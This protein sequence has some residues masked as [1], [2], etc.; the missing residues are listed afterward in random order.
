[1]PK[2]RTSQT[3]E[4]RRRERDKQLKRQAKL[5][6]R[7]ERNA[8]KRDA[9]LDPPPQAPEIPRAASPVAEGVVPPTRAE[10]KP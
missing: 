5:A 7:Q 9:K 1:M 10:V 4:K 8:A 6:K 2:S 3:Q